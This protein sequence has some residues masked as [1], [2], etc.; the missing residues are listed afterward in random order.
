MISA[1]TIGLSVSTVHAQ[2]IGAVPSSSEKINS[3]WRLT[4]QPNALPMTDYCRTTTVGGICGPVALVVRPSVYL[5]EDDLPSHSSELM[6]ADERVGMRWNGGDIELFLS[7]NR[8][9]SPNDPE[10]I[11]TRTEVYTIAELPFGIYRYN[12]ELNTSGSWRCSIYSRT[13]CYFSEDR[14]FAKTYYFSWS[15]EQTI[16]YPYRML[17]LKVG[18]D[19]GVAKIIAAANLAPIPGAKT[20]VIPSKNSVCKVSASKRVGTVTARKK[21]TCEVRIRY[22]FENGEKQ[23]VNFDVKVIA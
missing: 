12:W 23:V 13:G 8:R 18:K 4:V 22:T 15:G 19:I 20:N 10:Y 2:Q 9:V 16:I 3:D 17:K 6:R 11:S 7:P 1:F 14:S 5:T 21:G